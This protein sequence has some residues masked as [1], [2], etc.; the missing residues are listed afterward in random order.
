MTEDA[1]TSNVCMWA[2]ANILLTEFSLQTCL[3]KMEPHTVQASLGLTSDLGA[4]D[5]VLQIT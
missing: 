1:T 3:F 4:L 5:S 2:L